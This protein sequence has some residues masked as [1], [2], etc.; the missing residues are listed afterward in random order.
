MAGLNIRSSIRDESDPNIVLLNDEDKPT[1]RVDAIELFDG[2]NTPQN[3]S[4]YGFI[5]GMICSGGIMFTILSDTNIPH[6]G[7]FLSALALFH[8]L[9][10]VATALFNADKLSLDCKF[11]LYEVAFLYT[12]CCCFYSLSY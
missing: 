10:Y 11:P 4:V 6:F 9:E 8:F 1:R 3:I 12:Y 5:L 2:K 7:I